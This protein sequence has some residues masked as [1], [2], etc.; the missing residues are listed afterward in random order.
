MV[1][2]LL[3]AHSPEIADLA[4]CDTLVELGSGTSDKT[5]LLLDAMA[6]AGTLRRYAPLDV[7]EQTLRAA[8][9]GV[10]AEYLG[11]EIRAVVGDFHRHLDS[12]PAGRRRL[13]AFLGSTIGNLA[14]AARS[15]FLFDLDCT[16]GCDD[17]VLFSVDL[18]K[19]PARLIAAYD[20][21]SGVTAEF[22]RN[23]LR[24][25][26]DELDATFAPGL[27]DHVAVW[28]AERQWIEMRLRATVEHAVRVEA[29]GGRVIGVATGADY[30]AR[31][32]MEGGIPFPL[33]VDRDRNLHRAL[34]LD[35]IR[36]YRFLQPA[37]WRRY[38]RASRGAR[39]G[40]LTGDLRQAPGVAVI[41]TERR[42][43]YFHPGTTL[44]DYPPLEEVLA[45]LR[46]IAAS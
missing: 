20:D 43:R 18:V 15:R 6:A 22:N 11:V 30:P 17:R 21:A 24:L 33:L 10:A 3:G 12:L 35:H 9:A 32:L 40:R 39:Q 29:L 13:V 7:S 4:G 8:A 27:F 25:L 26:N 38:L 34:G 46:G 41:D 44:G 16:V 2:R 37:T 36:W 31:Q 14:P 1:R 19:D 45:A 42:L 5:R 28:D 23:A